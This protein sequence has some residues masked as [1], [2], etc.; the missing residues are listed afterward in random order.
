MISYMNNKYSVPLEYIGKPV[1]LRVKLNTL[2]IYFSTE[3]IARHELSNR[4][5]NYQK[6]H[7]TNLLSHYVKDKDT[8]AEIAQAN[9]QLMD[10]FL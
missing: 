10:Q 8:V 9:L 6:E 4:K 3:L 7:Y 2:E 1:N 5:L